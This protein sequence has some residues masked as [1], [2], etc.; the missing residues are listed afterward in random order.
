MNIGGYLVLLLILSSFLMI[1]CSTQDNGE[2]SKNNGVQIAN[3]ASQKCVDDGFEVVIR[4][5]DDGSQNGYCIF[6]DSSECEEWSYFRGE[7]E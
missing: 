5:A 2:I 1:S 3:P 7:C 6:P 4:T